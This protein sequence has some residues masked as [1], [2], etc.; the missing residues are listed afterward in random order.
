MLAPRARSW[1]TADWS[2]TDVTPSFWANAYGGVTVDPSDP[3]GDLKPR[4]DAPTLRRLGLPLAANATK[5]YALL[6]LA[7]NEAPTEYWLGEENFFVI[8][9]Y[10][11]SSF[12]AM[13]VFQ[14]GEKLREAMARPELLTS[15]ASPSKPEAMPRS[16]L[17][18]VMKKK[19]GTAAKASRPAPRRDHHTA[20]NGTRH[21]A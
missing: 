19:G 16:G 4:Y 17:G 12:Y 15:L 8:T 10:N 13:A 7:S 5:S 9:R 3:P 2:F 21:R 6:D 18:K 1:L 14:L 20:G 11:R